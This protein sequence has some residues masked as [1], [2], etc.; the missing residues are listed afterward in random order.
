MCRAEKY[1][2]GSVLDRASTARLFLIE[3]NNQ[4]FCMREETQNAA[5]A[6]RPDLPLVEWELVLLWTF[7]FA[8]FCPGAPC[9]A[10]PCTLSLGW[11][12]VFQA[13][14]HPSC[15]AFLL[16]LIPAPWWG[17]SFCPLPSPCLASDVLH[18]HI[19]VYVPLWRQKKSKQKSS[20]VR[21]YLTCPFLCGL[22]AVPAHQS[23]LSSA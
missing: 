12:F 9:C 19:L 11:A 13:L 18:W 10:P 3:N 5:A 20:C 6:T 17:S 7:V 16:P 2:R 15:P 14:P 21:S 23:R 4:V 22:A 1:L 8:L